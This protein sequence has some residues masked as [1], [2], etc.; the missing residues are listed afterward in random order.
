VSQGLSAIRL[1]RAAMCQHMET[2]GS[3]FAVVGLGNPGKRYK[4][5]RH[6]AGFRVIDELSRKL[7]IPLKEQDYQAN[8]GMELVAGREIL[9]CQPLTFMNLSGRV[10]GSMLKDFNIP[11]S[12]ILVVHDDLDL[13]CGRIKLA[14]RGGAGGH[15]GVLSIIEHLG[16]RDFPRLK[17]G[18]GRPQQ[19]ES[20][21]QFVLQPP[22]A[23]ERAVFEDMVFQGV[24][25]VQAVARDGLAVA[26]NRFNRTAF[27]LESSTNGSD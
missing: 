13:P 26:M 3:C 27:P 1:A 10:V 24:E 4:D 15:R 17:L 23:D 22:Y 16:H 21:E 11:A 9:L 14:Q 25:A 2:K 6:N 18:V 8:W 12:K 7:L 19:G 20:V 5:T